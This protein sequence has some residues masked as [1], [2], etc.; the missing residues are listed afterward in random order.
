MR[1]QINL[2]H[3]VEVPTKNFLEGHKDDFAT[4][5]NKIKKIKRL[6]FSNL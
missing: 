1:L 2:S 3:L 4:S 5:L 6:F